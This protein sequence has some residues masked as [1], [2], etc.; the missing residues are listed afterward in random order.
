M[1]PGRGGEGA[2]ARNSSFFMYDARRS[3]RGV[4]PDAPLRVDHLRRFRSTLSLRAEVLDTSRIP[5][6]RAVR[7]DGA[8]LRRLHELV[9]LADELGYEFFGRLLQLAGDENLRYLWFL[10]E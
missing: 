8:H 10:P 2:V 9:L 7:V 6:G 3:S 5:Q 4:S 1:R